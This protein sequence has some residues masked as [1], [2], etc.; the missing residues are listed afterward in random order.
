MRGFLTLTADTE[1]EIIV[2]TGLANLILRMRAQNGLTHLVFLN[3]EW[4]K[5]NQKALA[6]QG[7]VV[8]LPYRILNISKTRKSQ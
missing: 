8:I 4:F 3:F 1:D 2:Y 5:I 6:T 7:L